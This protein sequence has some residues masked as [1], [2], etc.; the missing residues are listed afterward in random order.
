MP[1]HPYFLSAPQGARFIFCQPELRC[2]R[3][4]P[5][6]TTQDAPRVICKPLCRLLLRSL[7]TPSLP[8]PNSCSDRVEQVPRKRE[9]RNSDLCKFCDPG[10]RNIKTGHSEPKAR[11][12]NMKR[13]D[14]QSRMPPQ[15]PH[16]LVQLLRLYLHLDDEE[17]ARAVEKQ[18]VNRPPS[19]DVEDTGISLAR[20]VSPASSK[21][22]FA[23][24]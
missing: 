17:P 11:G 20:S 19:P 5:S 24:R 23:A 9:T 8:D 16:R 18:Q 15:L 1:A 12:L 21:S 22:G 3:W 6:Q 13:L 7:A 4:R 2:S 10:G 14:V